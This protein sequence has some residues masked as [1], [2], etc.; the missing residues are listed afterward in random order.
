M[1]ITLSPQ[2]R[3]EC[4]YASVEGDTLTLN[5]ETFDF[6]EIPEGATLPVAAISSNWFA[7][8]VERKEG[9][10]RVVLFLPHGCK[11]PLAT[12]F[13]EPITISSGAIDLPPYDLA[14]GEPE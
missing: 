14:S 13:P 1:R 10:L 9:Q 12:R 8:D 6:S 11:A 7:G 3:T 2:H 4:L 5:G